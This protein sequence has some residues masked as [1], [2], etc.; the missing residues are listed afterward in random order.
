MHSMDELKQALTRRHFFGL[1]S[2]GLGGAALAH[3]SGGAAAARAGLPGIPHHPPAAKHVIYLHQSGGPSQMDLFDPKPQLKKHQG[4]EL[5]A[6]VRMG[7]RITGMTS[8]QSSLPVAS[9][10]FQFQQH[11][12]SGAWLS[13]LLPHTAKVADELTIIRTMHTEAINHDP[14]I[15]FIQSGSQQPGRPSMGAWVSYGLGSD[16]DNLPAFVVLI[17]QANA[18][19]VDQPLFS[20]LWGNGFLPSNHQGV[21]FRAGSEPV[22]YLDDPQGISRDTR[23]DML[24]VIGKINKIRADAYHDPEIETRISQYEMAYRMQTS[25]PDLMD[26]SKEP[27]S[28][29]AAYGPEARK[30]GSYA[31]NCLLARR[32]VERG[33]RFV[34]LYHRGWDQHNDLPRD[35]AL[36]CKGT[37]QAS[38]ALVADLKQR[39]LLK[40]TLVV[41]GGEF[42][43][44]TYC[45]GKLTETN[46]GRDHHPRCFTMWMAGGGVKRGF[47]M[48]ETDDFS[49][50]IVN[51]GVHVHDLQT[52]ILHCLGVDHKRLTFKYQGRHFRLT[53]IHGE[54]VTKVLA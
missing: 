43:R 37:D 7:Q 6:S 8:G 50:N 5:P 23:R 26:L 46:Y 2:T 41:W 27:E 36:Q 10:V 31:S 53:D 52:T 39:G 12:Q 21:R 1:T 24:D 40:D 16:N 32:L 11:G 33:V 49:Y 35:L 22:L 19:N 47:T 9:S 14:A 30:P 4:T 29:F 15:T 48:G 17:S 18:L 3:L 54:L 44:T 38:A 28:T 20:R 13:E 42:G 25:V 51:D 34:Q 45:Q